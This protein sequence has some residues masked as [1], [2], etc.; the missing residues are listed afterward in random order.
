MSKHISN[1]TMF[2]PSDVAFIL[3]ATQPVLTHSRS[4]V[5]ESSIKPHAHPRGQLLWAAKGILRVTS[6]KGVWVVPSTHAVWIPGGHYHQVSNETATQTRNLY[7][8]PSFCVR[9]N[10]DKVIMLKVSSLMR[11]IILKLTES[12]EPLTKARAHHLGLVALDELESLEALEL[13]IPSGNDPRLQRLIS[14]IVNH[15]EQSLL[16]EELATQV[17]ASVRTIER[18][19]KAETGLTF[20]QWR[21]RFRLMNSLEKIAQGQNT[22]LVAHQLGYSSVSSFISSFKKLFGCTPQEYAQR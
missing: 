19:F 9:Q 2:S 15:P 21:S 7:I 10:S 1:T 4:M 11:E 16:L 13:F 12:P 14:I 5:A 22:T 20:R 6:E 17:G 18:L 3:D 8:D